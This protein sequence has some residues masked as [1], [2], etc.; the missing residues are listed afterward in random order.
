MKLT[1]RGFTLVEL[2]IVIAIIGIL[3]AA[4]FPALSGYLASSR[5][6]GR[7]ANL[8]NIQVA[9]AAYFTNNS[10]FSGLVAANNCLATGSLQ[11]YMGNKVPMDSRTT[12]KFANC[13]IPSNFAAGTGT[14]NGSTE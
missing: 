10:T 13:G 8:R 1:S 4:L 14:S 3:A 11:S 9:A 12:A 5:D 7:A 2:M 6:A